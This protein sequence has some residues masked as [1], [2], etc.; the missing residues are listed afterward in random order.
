MKLTKFVLFIALVSLL[1]ACDSPQENDPANALFQGIAVSETDDPMVPLVAVHEDG[2]RAALL[3]NADQDNIRGAVYT[4]GDQSLVVYVDSTGRPKRAFSEGHVFIYGNYEADSVDVAVVNPDG[5][6]EITRSIGIETPLPTLE[7]YNAASEDLGAEGFSHPSA[8][9]AATTLTFAGC[10]AGA[11]SGTEAA[12]ASAVCDA[13]LV[14][15]VSSYSESDHDAVEASSAAI[16]MG[17]SDCSG[18][19]PAECASLLA[20]QTA[21][22]YNSTESELSEREDAVYAAAR[23]LEVGGVWQRRGYD[24]AYFVIKEDFAADVY[25]PQSEDCYRFNRGEFMS[26]SA[27]EDRFTYENADGEIEHK[28][29]VLDEEEGN[30]VLRVVNL[31]RADYLTFDQSDRAMS[32]FSPQCDMSS[33]ARHQTRGL[34]DTVLH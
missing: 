4:S 13:P 19:E 31:D 8:Q 32:S 21:A 33:S 16:G 10:A 14:D 30:V 1:G 11:A 17:A 29:Y 24:D 23:V 9:F 5:E 20:E 12:L 25:I 28:R 18:S 22:T 2:D 6:M 26:A 34:P 3:S 15:V 27:S 7:Q